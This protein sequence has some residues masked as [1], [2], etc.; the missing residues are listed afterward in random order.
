LKY[1]TIDADDI[2][3]KITFQYL[4]NSPS[5][6]NKLSVSLDESTKRISSLLTD[7]GFQVIFCA[8]DGIAGFTKE[9]IDFSALFDSVSDQSPVEFSYSAGVGGT[10]RE[11]YMALMLAKSDGK[12]C[13]RFFDDLKE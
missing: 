3:R 13:L 11:A 4:N 5:E 9:K 1:L 2:G 6:L 7:L 12:N 8:A 10:L